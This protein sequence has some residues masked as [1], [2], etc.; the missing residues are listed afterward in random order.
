[1]S[2]LHR[3]HDILFKAHRDIGDIL[4]RDTLPGFR[5]LD[6]IK[7]VMAAAD[8]ERKNLLIEAK[9]KGGNHHEPANRIQDR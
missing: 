4:T 1:M 6:M 7:V 3:D 5:K 8:C 9:R 2:H